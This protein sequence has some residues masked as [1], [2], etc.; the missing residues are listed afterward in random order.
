MS[1][2]KVQVSDGFKKYQQKKH[3]AFDKARKA[4]NTLGG[5]PMPID[6]NF[7][8]KFVSVKADVDD[9]GRSYVKM[10][11]VVTFPEQF[12]G[13]KVGNYWLLFDSAN[14]TEADR[15][16][17]ML[18]EME[19]MGLPREIRENHDDFVED[20]LGW[21]VSNEPTCKGRVQK[22]AQ[23]NDGK[24][25][26]WAKSAVEEHAAASTNDMIGA[27]SQKAVSSEGT[28]Y[29]VGQ[30]VNWNGGLW[31]VHEIVSDGYYNLKSPRTEKIQSEVSGADLEP[32]A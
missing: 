26:R 1:S 6:T 14:A 27:P 20:V 25:I 21:F 16:G 19:N 10:D 7:E 5:I 18:N 12:A 9:K 30:K 31:I 2:G 24:R 13:K 29:Q 23:A 3:A 22:D 15:F 28:E 11:M 4:E 8:A 32:V 17:W